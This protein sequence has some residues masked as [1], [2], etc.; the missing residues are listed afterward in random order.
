M[1][2]QQTPQQ[3]A[4]A[5]A[6]ALAAKGTA[7]TARA[8]RERARVDMKVATAAAKAWKERDAELREIPAAPDTVLTRMDALWREAVMAARGE[9]QAERDGWAAQM[10]E[11]EEEREALG[12]DIDRAEKERDKAIADAKAQAEDLQAQIA[13]LKK[14]LADAQESAKTAAAGTAAAEARANAAE[15]IAQGLREALTALA[16]KE[17]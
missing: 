7:V 15:G 11:A 10:S 6:E 12:E 1:V 4:E 16:P 5:A 2:D 14:Q 8:V 3:K 9:H 17:P 13:E